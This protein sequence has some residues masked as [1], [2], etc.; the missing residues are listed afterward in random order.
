M[1]ICVCD[2]HVSHEKVSAKQ[3]HGSESIG[4]GD[5]L[6]KSSLSEV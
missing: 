5:K 3:R 1:N 2:R 4:K 6:I